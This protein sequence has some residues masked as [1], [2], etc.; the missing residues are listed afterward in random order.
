MF[1]D[2]RYWGFQLLHIQRVRGC[3]ERIVLLLLIRDIFEGVDRIHVP[4]F[5][6]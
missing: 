5:P 4:V 6:R 3:L 1:N 2:R